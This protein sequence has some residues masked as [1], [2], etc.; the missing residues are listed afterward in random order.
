M[1]RQTLRKRAGSI[2]MLAVLLPCLMA[3][4]WIGA[5]VPASSGREIRPPG[6]RLRWT[7]K[8]EQTK[9]G[10]RGHLMPVGSQSAASRNAPGRAASGEQALSYERAKKVQ[11]TYA[12]Q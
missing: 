12:N 7:P 9:A 1:Q 2:P 11:L 8:G 5:I 6:V 4:E 3:A 10:S